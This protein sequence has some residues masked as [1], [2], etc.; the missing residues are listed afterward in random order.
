ML[1]LGKVS[2]QPRRRQT[3][4]TMQSVWFT[5]SIKYFSCQVYFYGM[6]ERPLAIFISTSV[7]PNIKNEIYNK[8]WMSTTDTRRLDLSACFINNFKDFCQTYGLFILQMSHTHTHDDSQ[9]TQFQG[10]YDFEVRVCKSICCQLIWQTKNDS[11][12]A[13]LIKKQQRWM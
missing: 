7:H 9:M 8:K 13:I 4:S 6:N 5:Q 2:H 1:E 3:T 10:Q 12:I 11:T